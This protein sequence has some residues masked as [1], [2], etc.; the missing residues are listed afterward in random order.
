MFLSL[1]KTI[2]RTTDIELCNRLIQN[3]WILLYVGQFNNCDS[4]EQYS[5]TEYTIG[6][7]KVYNKA[8]LEKLGCR[9]NVKPQ[10][11]NRL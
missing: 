2:Y 3:D 8:E 4:F 6:S 10:C 9:P 1:I 5:S 7:S 11:F